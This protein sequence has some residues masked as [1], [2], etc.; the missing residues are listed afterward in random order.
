MRQ[1]TQQR[2]FQEWYERLMPMGV[3]PFE[4]VVTY[5]TW[6]GEES[7]FSFDLCVRRYRHPLAGID[8][9]DYNGH[10]SN[11]SYAKVGIEWL[12]PCLTWGHDSA[13]WHT[14][15]SSDTDT[16]KNELVD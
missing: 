3:N 11:S 14:K 6:V 16:R 13:A 15:F 4:D 9:S 8:D 1:S 2:A 7:S 10:L 5:R 12:E